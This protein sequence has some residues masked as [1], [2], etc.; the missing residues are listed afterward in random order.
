MVHVWLGDPS[1]DSDLAFS[2]IQEE[3]DRWRISQ[4]HE[5]ANRK[6]SQAAQVPPK[7]MNIQ[8][9]ELT[10]DGPQVVHAVSSLLTR[11]WFQRTWIRQKVTALDSARVQVFSGESTGRWDDF[12]RIN[13]LLSQ[14][15][16]KRVPYP[17][18][19]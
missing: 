12:V 16:L 18:A 10:K 4:E 14:V 6:G 2:L 9:K 5:N 15:E 1:S 11:P 3:G 8:F 19:R 13:A 7:N 17:L